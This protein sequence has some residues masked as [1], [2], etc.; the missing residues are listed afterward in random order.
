M[1]VRA[2][3]VSA[4]LVCALLAHQAL[5]LLDLMPGALVAQ[6]L[7]PI[8]WDL[9]PIWPESAA[10]GQAENYPSVECCR[11]FPPLIDL[12]DAVDTTE[13]N[14]TKLV[15]TSPGSTYVSHVA[16]CRVPIRHSKPDRVF[17]FFHVSIKAN[18]LVLHQLSRGQKDELRNH[19]F[20]TKCILSGCRKTNGPMSIKFSDAALNWT[21][22]RTDF[23]NDTAMVHYPWLGLNFFHLH[24]ENLLSAWTSLRH[25]RLLR[26]PRVLLQFV[27]QPPY[28]NAFYSNSMQLIFTRVEN[29]TELA[30]SSSEP[31]CFPRLI[32]PTGFGV[33]SQTQDDGAGSGLYAPKMIKGATIEYATWLRRQLNISQPGLRNRKKP[34]RHIAWLLRKSD[35]REMN[36][37]VFQECANEMK[38]VWGN[39][40]NVEKLSLEVLSHRDNPRTLLLA[41]GD[42]DILVGSHGA[43][44]TN[45]LYMPSGGLVVEVFADYGIGLDFYERMAFQLNHTCV[46]AYSTETD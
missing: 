5:R 37:Q 45:M 14:L 27:G 21:E 24:N 42:V 15:A 43:G 13:R 8:S 30:L 20:F 25:L 35:E 44:L 4:A 34:P 7:S 18:T 31:Y 12:E 46:Q 6:P 10:W 38:R 17:E 3:L 33:W 39:E 1:R 11:I 28:N 29:I 9:L 32:I 41:M 26:S 22:C 40:V 36:S 19:R 23:I 16:K 2:L